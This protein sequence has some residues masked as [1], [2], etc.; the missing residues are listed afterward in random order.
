MNALTHLFFIFSAGLH[1]SRESVNQAAQG[2]GG[3]TNGITQGE[4]ETVAE[5][6]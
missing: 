4:G 1:D 6:P 3:A 2:V 5:V